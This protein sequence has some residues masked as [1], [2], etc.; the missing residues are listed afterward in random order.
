MCGTQAALA[1]LGSVADKKEEE[2]KALQDK[3]LEAESQR[4]AARAELESAGLR[5]ME[6]ET[7]RD[8][9]LARAKEAERLVLG[10]SSLLWGP[11]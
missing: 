8:A 6:V 10:S 3:V 7:E 4:E 9:A 11:R 5:V 2:V 1:R